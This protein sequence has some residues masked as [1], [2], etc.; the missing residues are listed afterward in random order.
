MTS[1]HA[2]VVNDKQACE[3]LM[4]S[5]DTR[6]LNDK[7]RGMHDGHLNHRELGAINIEAGT[8]G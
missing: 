4:T 5:S 1:R 3:C 6:A 8:V 2:R 7:Q